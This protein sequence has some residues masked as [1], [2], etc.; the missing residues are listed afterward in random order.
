MPPAGAAPE[1]D[2][3]PE[4]EPGRESEPEPGPDN[5]VTCDRCAAVCCRETV[6]CITDQDLPQH[7]IDEGAEGM[8]QMRRLDDGWCIA[9]N[10]TEMNCGIYDRRPLPCRL[11]EMGGPDCLAVRARFAA[12]SD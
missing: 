7:L 1:P 11:F 12:T 2:P 10:R 4:R 5:G 8:P 6:P 3:D 9:L